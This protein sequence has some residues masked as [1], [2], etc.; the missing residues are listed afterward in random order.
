[1]TLVD[2]TWRFA[3][4]PDRADALS[5]NLFTPLV[6][7]TNHRLYYVGVPVFD[8]QGA[9]MFGLFATGTSTKVPVERIHQLTDRLHDAALGIMGRIGSRIP[10]GSAVERRRAA[11]R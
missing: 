8:P 7:G 4:E 6:P 10:E 3:V 1:V 5:S 11:A 9:V 2:R